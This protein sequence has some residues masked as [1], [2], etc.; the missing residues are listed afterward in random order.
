MYL[1]ISTITKIDHLSLIDA[2]KV[3]LEARGEGKRSEILTT[4][5]AIEKGLLSPMQDLTKL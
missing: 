3:A 2:K 5:Q 4:E 1:V